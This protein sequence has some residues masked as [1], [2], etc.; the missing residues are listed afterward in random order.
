MSPRTRTHAGGTIGA[1]YWQV[2]ED[3]KTWFE[4]ELRSEDGDD[5]PVEE[6]FEDTAA[7]HR[8]VMRLWSS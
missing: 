5:K 6:Q 2:E 1:S 3:G 7:A 4:V 8:Y